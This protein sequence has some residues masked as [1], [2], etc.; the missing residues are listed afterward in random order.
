MGPDRHLQ[1]SRF[2][3]EALRDGP[4]LQKCTSGRPVSGSELQ[5][6]ADDGPRTDVR[7]PD[8][9]GYLGQH[10]EYS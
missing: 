5:S 3:F 10:F 2:S 7:S 6:N 8:A 1:G 4:L 9:H